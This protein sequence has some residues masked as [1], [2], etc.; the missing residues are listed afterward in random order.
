MPSEAQDRLNAYYRRAASDYDRDHVREHDEHYVA[1]E[2]T[3]AYVERAEV[4]SVLDVGCGTG[5]ALEW[6]AQHI[7]DLTRLAGVDPSDDMVERARQRVPSAELRVASADALPF[8]D[9]SFDLV[10]ATGILHHVE[11]P[12]RCIA[13]MFRVARTAVLISDHNCFA[14]GGS[15]ARRLRLA[16]YSVGLLSLATFVKQGFR[17]QGYSE[18]DGYWYPY[19]LLDDYATVA[20]LAKEIVLL[21]VRPTNTITFGNFLLSQSHLA[22]W[23]LK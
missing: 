10:C 16:L 3:L 21:P 12:R 19:S 13:E 1:L 2:R 22:F 5:R 9:A 8:E 14:F 6:Y 7:P 18:G 23:A 20:G 17:R 15:T 4:R 11:H